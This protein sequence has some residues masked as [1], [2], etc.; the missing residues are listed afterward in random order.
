M[1]DCL[2]DIAWHNMLV[3]SCFP[4]E[5]VCF[6]K[7]QRFKMKT[8]TFLG[9]DMFYALLASIEPIELYWTLTLIILNAC[10]KLVM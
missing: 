1:Y 3:Y 10:Y 7:T 4:E 6:H 9:M 8:Q 2:V 5:H